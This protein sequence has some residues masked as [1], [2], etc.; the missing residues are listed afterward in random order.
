M[1]L[2]YNYQNGDYAV[3]HEAHTDTVT[4]ELDGATDMTYTFD[5]SHWSTDDFIY[6]TG[7]SEDDRVF[8]LEHLTCVG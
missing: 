8:V 2:I 3:A 5:I 4:H 7:L 6:F 1:R